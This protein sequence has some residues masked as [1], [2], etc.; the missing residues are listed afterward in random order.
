MVV[1]ES[2]E[3]SRKDGLLKIREFNSKQLSNVH[4][5]VT[6]G[7]RRGAGFPMRCSKGLLSSNPVPSQGTKKVV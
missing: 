5:D 4:M 7:K 6:T 1:N 2:G 3:G